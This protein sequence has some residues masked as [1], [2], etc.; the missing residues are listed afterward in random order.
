VFVFEVLTGELVLASNAITV[1]SDNAAPV[2]RSVTFPV[3]LPVV[4]GWGSSFEQL[5]KIKAVIN[6]A[7]KEVRRKAF[8]F[9]RVIISFWD[10]SCFEIL[11]VIIKSVYGTM[12]IM[13]IL[14]R[15]TDQT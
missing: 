15:L 7:E 11:F 2:D 1:A 9:I 4:T 6:N 13:A 14:I 3:I 8:F 5:E 12:R 10:L